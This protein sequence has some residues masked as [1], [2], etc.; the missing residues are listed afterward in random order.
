M[1]N[2]LPIFRSYSRTLTIFL[3][4]VRFLTETRHK[5]ASQSNLSVKFQLRNREPPSVSVFLASREQSTFPLCCRGCEPFN[6]GLLLRWTLAAWLHWSVYK[7]YRLFCEVCVWL[8]L[9][10]VRLTEKGLLESGG[11]TDSCLSIWGGQWPALC[12]SCAFPTGMAY[13]P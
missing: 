9:S 7:K 8:E 12:R 13:L 1:L 2:W 4:K 6:K 11:Q 5:P 3:P 10:S